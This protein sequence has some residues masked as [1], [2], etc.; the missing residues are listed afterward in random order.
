MAENP[1]E[2]EK[3]TPATGYNL[4]SVEDI[5]LHGECLSF[6]KHFDTWEEATKERDKWQEAGANVVI[7]SRRKAK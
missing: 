5:E 7:L 3:N 4:C 1:R 2:I 6:I